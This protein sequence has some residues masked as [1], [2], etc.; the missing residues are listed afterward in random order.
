MKVFL[1]LVKVSVPSKSR[2]CLDLVRVV[3]VSSNGVSERI[4]RLG[5]QRWLFLDVVKCLSGVGDEFWI[6]WVVERES[7]VE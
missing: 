5:R 2:R 1:W 3:G 7:L 6:V 4:L